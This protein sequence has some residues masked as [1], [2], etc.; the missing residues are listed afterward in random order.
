[1]GKDHSETVSRRCLSP[2]LSSEE[3][4]RLYSALCT[5]LESMSRADLGRTVVKLTG[6][7]NLDCY[8]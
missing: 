8:T 5:Q 7:V 1:M 4:H 3:L 2:S 6:P